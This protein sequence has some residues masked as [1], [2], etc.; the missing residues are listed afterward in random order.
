MKLLFDIGNTRIKWAY[1]T[2]TELLH[3]GEALHRGRPEDVQ[4][5][6]SGLEQEPEEI[7]V[8]NVAGADFSTGL[9]DT[10]EARFGVTPQFVKTARRCGEVVNGYDDVS[11][12]GVDRWAAV[13]GAWNLYRS[14]VCVVDAGTAMTIDLV[15][16]DGR[17]EGGFILPGIQLMA[18]ALHRDTSDIEAFSGQ[19]KALEGGR[20]CG[21]DTLSA[22]QLGAVFAL[23]ATVTEA[24]RRL[25]GQPAVVF[26]GGDA[27]ALIP[28]PD[29]EPDIRP[30]LVIEG[31]RQLAA[32]QQ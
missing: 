20:W 3:A 5:I 28:L 18:D 23:R 27:H 2:G 9:T 6:V 32:M 1:D 25:G 22:V 24:V 11:Q 12:H 31:L 13:V 10:A 8:V 14:D 4:Q 21:T 30:M 16:A 7:W 15:R 17:H 26:T 19:G 29:F